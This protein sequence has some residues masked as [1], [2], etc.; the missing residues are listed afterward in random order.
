MKHFIFSIA[1][2][3]FTCALANGQTSRQVSGEIIDSTKMPVAGVGIK[4]ISERG[5]SI[6][7][8][9]SITGYFSFQQVKGSRLTLTFSSI[10][11]QGVK[12]HYVLDNDSKP[13]NLGVIL[14][15]AQPNMLNQVNIVGVNPVTIKEDTI[16]YKVSAYKVRDNAPLEDALKKMP[17]V[18]VDMN[19]NVSAQGKK[20]SKVRVNGKDFFGGDVRTAT[21]NLPADVVQSVQIID[22]YGDQANLTGIK[23]GEP[24]KIM[25]I[26]IRQDKNHG[27]SLQA[28]AGDGA[29]ALPN[30]PG[31]KNDNRYIGLIN[32]FRFNGDQQIA[33]LGNANNT[34]VNT[35]SF[36][37]PAT[38][39]GGGSV[40]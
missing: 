9:T 32:S 10:G 18:D 1:A 33:L 38:S 11:Y 37:D 4:L 14:L 8:S 5:D 21:Q 23:T 35:F 29:D 22:D 34:N 2:V 17:G 3:L 24:D 19:G 6:I 27:Y 12:K 26:M 39:S 31:V 13:V 25:N 15:H 36:G 20:V 28:T 40:L 30:Q 16:E 7:T